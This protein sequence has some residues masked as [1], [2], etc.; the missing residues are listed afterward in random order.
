[1]FEKKIVKYQ[2]YYDYFLNFDVACLLR[3]GKILPF[4]SMEVLYLRQKSYLEVLYL[5]QKS[6]LE[7]LYLRQKVIWRYCTSGKKLFGGNVPAS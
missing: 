4:F 7:V 5:H 6:Y 1:M 2:R 3:K